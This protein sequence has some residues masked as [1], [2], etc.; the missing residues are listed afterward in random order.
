MLVLLLLTGDALPAFHY[1][2]PLLIG[3]LLLS[4]G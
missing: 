4:P 2:P 1:A 3:I